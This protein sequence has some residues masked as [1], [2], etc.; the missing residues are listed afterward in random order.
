MGFSVDSTR[1]AVQAWQAGVRFDRTLALGQQHM[2]V[3]PERIEALLREH[4]V[5]PPPGGESAFREAL[6]G[7]DWRFASFLRALGAQQV[8]SVDASA[9]EGA[10]LVHDLNQPIP[11]EWES[12]YDVVVDGGTLEHV[13][14]FPVAISNCMRMVKPGGHLML[15]TPTNNY[16]GHGFY[17]FSPELLF[18]VLSQENGY[19]VRRMVALQDGAG[20]SSVLGVNYPFCFGGPW[21]E[22]NDPAAIRQRVNLI[23]NL[24]TLLMV[25]ARRTAAVTP[26]KTT[27]QQSDYV[28]QWQEGDVK[29]PNAQAAGGGMEAWLRARFSET[30]CRETLPRLALLLDPFR[31]GRFRRQFSFA[32]R[33]YFRPVDK[34]AQ[35]SAPVMRKPESDGPG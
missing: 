3:G 2:M 1:F 8:D 34:A 30:F 26:F 18:R 11:S 20:V 32:N 9:Y 6:R 27:P 24:P 16:C 23:T 10:A 17:Q 25:V 21:H 13:F 35:T 15:L 19:E 22:V 12:R 14:N 28:T 7:P 33:D 5:W 29:P 4:G 31:L